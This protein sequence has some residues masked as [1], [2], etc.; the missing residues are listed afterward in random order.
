MKTLSIVVPFHNE[1][2]TLKEL[3]RQLSKL[4]PGTFEECIFVNDGST[5]RSLELLKSTLVSY[6]LPHKIVNKANGGKASAV[7]EASSLLKTS[8]VV[9]LDA[10]LELSTTD[11]IRLWDI[12]LSGESEVVFGY[13]KFLAQS[14]YT[15]RYSRGNQFLSHIYGFLFNEVITDIMCGY[16]LLP[17]RHLQACPFNYSRFG[18]DVEIPLHLW[19]LRLRPYEVL[20]DYKPRSHE[21]GKVIGPKDA[22]QIILNLVYF[23]ITKARKRLP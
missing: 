4:P 6:P 11:L 22:L 19:L 7:K 18:V 10:D 8:H 21:D 17:S 9:I 23:R 13:R 1:E 12:V 3:V 15:Y 16:K 2:R 20:V 14:A 5:D